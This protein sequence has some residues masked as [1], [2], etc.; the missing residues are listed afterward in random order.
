MLQIIC[1]SG[2]N[3]LIVQKLWQAHYQILSITFLTVFIKFY[4]NTDTMIKNVKLVELNINIATAFLK[5]QILKTL[6]CSKNHQQM[7][8]EKLKDLFNKYNFSNHDNNKLILLL[9]KGVY[10]QEYMDDQ[11]ELNET[12]LL[13]KEDFYGHLNM[14]DS[15]DVD[16]KQTK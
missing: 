11:E 10:F 8:D 15:N 6:C 9:C 13:E 2:Y 5:P 1:L 4:G 12:S 3:L 16:Y 14:V 7:F